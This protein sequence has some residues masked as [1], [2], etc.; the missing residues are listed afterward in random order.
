MSCRRRWASRWRARGG[1]GVHA[2]VGDL[3]VVGSVRIGLI[4]AGVMGRIHARCLSRHVEGGGLVALA[5]L[6]REKAGRCAEEFGATSLYR[7]HHSLLSDRS[8][9]A[10]LICTP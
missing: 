9:D 10:V 1:T 4:G 6:D 3:T 5:D 2:I 7:D 8:I